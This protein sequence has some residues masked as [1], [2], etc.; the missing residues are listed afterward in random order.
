VVLILAGALAAAVGTVLILDSRRPQINRAQFG[1]IKEGMT[2]DQVE[3]V[4]GGPA[5]DYRWRALLA[6]SPVDDRAS[7]KLEEV[8]LS[9]HEIASAERAFPAHS[10]GTGRIS[11]RTW[12]GDVYVICVAFDGNGV[13]AGHSLWA[14]D[15]E[16][17]VTPALF[18]NWPGRVRP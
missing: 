17:D 11:C 13:T 9:V 5:G 14:V 4:L 18:R 15:P 6:R 7:T 16:P 2:L 8:G 12:W 1:R 10:G 3:A